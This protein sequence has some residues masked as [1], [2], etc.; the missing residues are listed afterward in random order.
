MPPMQSSVVTLQSKLGQK[1]LSESTPKNQAMID[2][3][4][5]YG[6]MNTL[7]ATITLLSLFNA[8][9]VA[10]RVKMSESSSEEEFGRIQEKL[11]AGEKIS[12]SIEEMS[13]YQRK[14]IKKESGEDKRIDLSEMEH[15]AMKLGFGTSLKFASSDE[16]PSKKLA[17]Y[18][19]G[20]PSI[21]KVLQNADQFKSFICKRI[22]VGVS[23]IIANYD[24]TILFKK[25]EES[26]KGAPIFSLLA[27]CKDEYILLLDGGA[28]G[29]LWVHYKRFFEAMDKLDNRSGL[30]LGT[31]TIYELM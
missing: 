20:D 19:S 9:K 1:W 2:E 25:E 16:N 5:K 23:G 31:L 4:G 3:Y 10:P 22:N 7:S 17:E 28:Q 15:L 30:P 13:S 6:D 18:I 29:P 21:R 27:A 11:F 14:Y 24:K 8:I 12:I 26:N